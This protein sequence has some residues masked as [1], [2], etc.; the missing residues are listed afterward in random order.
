MTS[1][2]VKKLSAYPE[3]NSPITY[4]QVLHCTQGINE[5]EEEPQYPPNLT[6][7]QKEEELKNFREEKVKVI[8]C[9]D[10]AARG[11]DIPNVRHVV[12]AEFALNVVQHLHRIGRASRAGAL[13]K[14]TN[15]VDERSKDLVAS[16]L[17]SSTEENETVENS[18]SR[19]R[20]F[21]QKLKKVI[22]RENERR[23]E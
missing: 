22:R 17:Q 20:G 2:Q 3:W 12:Q 14:A 8:V 7:Q 13:G 23:I 5:E 16:I 10:A 19:R 6:P 4:E 21:R 11:L 1:A 15:I 18:F 9:T